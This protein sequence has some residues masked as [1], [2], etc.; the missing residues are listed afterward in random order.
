MPFHFYYQSSGSSQE[1]GTAVSYNQVGEICDELRTYKRLHRMLTL[2]THS[3]MVLSPN[4]VSIGETFERRT[5]EE[6]L[7]HEMRNVRQ[8]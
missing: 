8:K 6:Q 5:I 3:K 7:T 4:V 2:P 1:G